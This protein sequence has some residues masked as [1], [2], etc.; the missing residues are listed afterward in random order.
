[1]RGPAIVLLA[2]I[3]FAGTHLALG[4]PPLR[5]RLAIRMGEQ[6]FV[7]LFSG[8]AA[9]T[10]G[11]L[12]IAVAVFGREGPAGAGL[13]AVPAARIALSVA[14]FLGLALAMGGIVHY[15]RSPMALFRTR[16]RPPSGLERITRHAFFVGISI[17]A[18]A[19][20]LIAPTLAIAI[21][22]AGFAALSL[23][24][25]ALQDRKLLQKWG[26]PYAEYLALTSAFPGVALL[27][28]RQSMVK[29]EGLAKTLAIAVAIAGALLLLHPLLS[30]F[31]GAPFAGLI[32]VGGLVAS[33]RRWLY[34]R[35][36]STS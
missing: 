10:F 3:A 31:N 32:A 25:M 7:A 11:L 26:E 14:A 24:G 13:N 34:S 18:A 6:A 28:R 1:M 22:F 30:A 4:L 2:W 12:A 33:G 5:D 35:R 27:Q 23:V 9:L 20:A 21:Y 8:V 29:G 16:I 15:N 17:F 19:H 36:V